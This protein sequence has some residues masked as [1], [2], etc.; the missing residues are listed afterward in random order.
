M[1]QRL[2]TGGL[3]AAVLGLAQPAYATTGSRMCEIAYQWGSQ[4]AYFYWV[5]AFSGC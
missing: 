3:M 4:W 5:W 2:M 1:R